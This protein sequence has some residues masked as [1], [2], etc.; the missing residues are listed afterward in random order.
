MGVR[1]GDTVRILKL[2]SI[3]VFHRWLSTCLV[4]IRRRLAIAR[5]T[6]F[7]WF[8]LSRYIH[9]DS[10]QISLFF[11]I[12]FGFFRCLFAHDGRLFSISESPFLVSGRW[13][14]LTV[15]PSVARLGNCCVA[16]AAAGWTLNWAES[17]TNWRTWT[18]SLATLRRAPRLRLD[19]T[20]I[21]SSVGSHWHLTA[22]KG[23]Q[24][25]LRSRRAALVVINEGQ[26]AAG[27][28]TETAISSNW[29]GWKMKALITWHVFIPIS[30]RSRAN[31]TICTHRLNVVWQYVCQQ[32]QVTDKLGLQ[33]SV[34]MSSARLYHFAALPCFMARNHVLWPFS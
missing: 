6:E 15:L 9:L 25:P 20:S 29:W 28:K 33:I 10:F 30:I 4:F 3:V 13:V 22:R 8:V 21:E 24:T 2:V 16:C 31:S 23:T 11:S 18:S 32:T 34:T 5:W 27:F 19:W 17:W 26:V 7:H 12:A 14:T 1:M